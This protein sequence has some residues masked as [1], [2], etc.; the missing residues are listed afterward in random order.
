MMCGVVFF[1]LA[2]PAVYFF[3]RVF[4]GTSLRVRIQ[5]GA[6]VR[7]ARGSSHGL[8]ECSFISQ[9]TL[10]VRVQNCNERDLG[11]VKPLAQEVDADKHI[12][13]AQAKV[14]KNSLAPQ[15]LHFGVQVFG[16]Q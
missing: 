3:K 2:A 16:F 15:R 14:A 8:D 11:K 12:K 6:S 7:M 13:D 1:L 4:Y 10:L 9:K 5:N